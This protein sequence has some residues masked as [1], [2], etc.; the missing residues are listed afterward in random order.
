M[1]T[2]SL[3]RWGTAGRRSAPSIREKIAEF[4]PMVTASVMMA[5]AEKPRDFASKRRASLKSAI[6]RSSVLDEGVVRI[7][8]EP[9]LPGLGRGDD[10]MFAGVRVFGGVFVWRR[11]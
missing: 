10:R 8:I 1:Q 6:M 9:A 5:T 3:G 4:T 2:T 7:A 11:V